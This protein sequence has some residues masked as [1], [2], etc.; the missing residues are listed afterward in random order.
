MHAMSAALLLPLL[1]VAACATPGTNLPALPDGERAAYRLGAEDKVRVTVFNDP[2]LTGEFRI[3]DDLLGGGIGKHLTTVPDID[4]PKSGK[5]ID[6]PLAIGIPEIDAFSLSQDER[7]IGAHVLE[8]GDRVQQVRLVFFDELSGIPGLC[9]GHDRTGLL[10]HVCPIL[11]RLCHER[12]RIRWSSHLER[13][14]ACGWGSG[15]GKLPGIE[16]AVLEHE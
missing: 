13:I 3:S 15:T 7:A 6:V 4:I 5:G 16:L 2:R 9:C 1:A 10:R 12:Y 14:A 8:I 11:L